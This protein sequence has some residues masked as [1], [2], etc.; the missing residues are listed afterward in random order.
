MIEIFALIA[1]SK[2][3]SARAKSQGRSGAPFVLLLI[4]LWFGGEIGGAIGGVVLS[5]IIDPG[6]EPNMLFCWLGAMACAIIGAAIAFQIVGPLET[7][8]SDSRLKVRDRDLP[9]LKERWNDRSDDRD[10]R[11]GSR[12][13]DDEKYKPGSR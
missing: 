6:S 3:I 9:I 1:M 8:Y 4:A 11:H 7:G 10:D 5:T 2:N 12:H 13:E